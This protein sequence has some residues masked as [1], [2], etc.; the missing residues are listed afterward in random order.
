M[1]Q[2]VPLIL[3]ITLASA[4]VHPARAANETRFLEIWK[5]HELLPDQHEGIIDLCR[6]YTSENQGDELLEAVRSIE[7]WHLLASG[8]KD[9]AWSILESQRSLSATPE[10][11]SA[12]RVAKGWLSRR[13]R[14]RVAAALQAYYRKEVCYPD[15]IDRIS[16]HKKIPPEIHPPSADA[17]GAPWDYRL[18]GK[19]KGFENQKYSLKCSELGDW[20]DLS[21][22]LAIPYAAHL[23][24]TPNEVTRGPSGESLVRFQDPETKAVSILS[25][26]KSSAQFQVAHVGTRIVVVCD[27]THWKVFPKP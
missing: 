21:T 22:S 27:A 17:F 7:A 26:G 4:L 8:R 2:L 13:D 15:S 11:A 1:R 18:S 5:R 19:I 25:E 9:E 3:L 10:E 23:T 24:A 16:S 14:E 12:A 20:S 6:K